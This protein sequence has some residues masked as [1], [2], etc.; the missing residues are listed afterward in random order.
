MATRAVKITKKG[1]VTLPKEIRERL[2][3]PAVYFELIDGNVVVRPLK[4]AAGS[5]SGYARNVKPGASMDELKEKAWEEAVYEKF[6]D[7]PT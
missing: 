5:L 1:Q 6:G 7:R 3:A 2:G 4:D